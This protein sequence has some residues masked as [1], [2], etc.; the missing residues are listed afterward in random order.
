[1]VA[2]T[3]V[4]QVEA[5]PLRI[6]LAGGIALG[7]SNGTTV[8]ERDFAGRQARRLFVRLAAVHE[9]VASADIADDLWGPEWP[10]AWQVALR[11]LVSKL[12]ATLGGV[13]AADAM[14]SANGT[15]AFVLP[16]GAW[17]DLE[18]AGEAIHR[19]EAALATG[20]HTRAAAAALVARSIA[21][22]PLM[23]GEEGDWLDLV[24]SRLA[25]V[26]LRALECL[27][28][29]WITRGDP[30]L[31]AR[32]AAEAIRVDPFRE[33]A[34]RLLIRAHIA[35]DDRG[36]A[37]HA[38]EACRRVLGEELGVEPSTETLALARAVLRS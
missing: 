30:A 17:L 19:A 29:V 32:D 10:A 25:E 6:Y 4:S 12:R 7:G 2:K 1:V 27:G 21:S 13:D 24:R 37:A 5:Q 33:S 18:A 20:D 16:A 38:Y 9:P 26:R 11:S 34:H 23:A 28:E 22:R 36:A 3:L 14:T 31:A 8:G 35:A 15:Y